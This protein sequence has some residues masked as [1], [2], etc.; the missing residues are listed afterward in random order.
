[1]KKI[2]VESIEVCNLDNENDIGKKIEENKRIESINNNNVMFSLN[3]S[4][5]NQNNNGFQCDSCK[6]LKES[7]YGKKNKKYKSMSA[8][9]DFTLVEKRRKVLIVEDVPFISQTIKVLLESVFENNEKDINVI[10]CF[11]GVDMLSEVIKDH[12]EGN[13]I[14]FIITDE[15]MDFVNGTVAIELLRKLESENRIKVPLIVSSTTEAFIERRLKDLKVE[16]ILPK[17]IHLNHLMNLLE[18]IKYFK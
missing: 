15:N 17:P 13:L 6:K 9:L 18:E 2:N 4:R 10:Q 8:S 16:K 12:K 7:P 1:M 3:S 5:G 11:D 14:D